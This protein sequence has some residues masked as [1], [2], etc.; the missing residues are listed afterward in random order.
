VPLT[1]SRITLFDIMTYHHLGFSTAR[2]IFHRIQSRLV[3][4]RQ[5]S[6]SRWPMVQ[7]GSS[8]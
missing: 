2:L 7:Q 8:R 6:R 5:Y 1:H 4:I 3:W